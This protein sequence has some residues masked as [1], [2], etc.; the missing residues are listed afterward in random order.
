M[1]VLDEQLSDARIVAAIQRWYR[2]K[3]IS[4]LEVRP[5]TRVLDDVIGVLLLR[6]KDPTFITINYHDFWRK[7]DAHRGFCVICFNL[8]MERAREIPGS[9]RMIFSLPE[10]S[11]KRKRM[12]KVISV[13]GRT[14]RYYQ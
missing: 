7:M 13:S 5:H 3:V 1:I 9:L 12:G 6:L 4:I 2:G 8:P 14:L 10:W 11:T